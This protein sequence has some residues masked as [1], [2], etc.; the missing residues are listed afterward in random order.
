MM[1]DL[2]HAPIVI[3][4]FVSFS[5]PRKPRPD[6]SQMACA[7]LCDHRRL[8]KSARPGKSNPLGTWPDRLCRDPVLPDS[9]TRCRISEG[10]F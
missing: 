5:L 2:S 3:S 10:P 4:W 7:L 9:V 8:N 6:P 1:S